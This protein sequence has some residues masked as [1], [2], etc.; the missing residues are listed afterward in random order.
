RGTRCRRPAR[1]RRNSSMP[2]GGPAKIPIAPMC[3]WFTSSSTW[4]N[5][6]SSGLRRSMGPPRWGG[7]RRPS[8]HVGRAAVAGARR[9]TGR[10]GRSHALVVLLVGLAGPAVSDL[11]GGEALLEVGDDVV[12]RLEADREAHQARVDARGELLLLGEL[13]VGGR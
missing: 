1:V 12:D 4:R 7:R 3:M 13:A 9:G 11:G 6:A 8:N 5:D 2:G 10:A